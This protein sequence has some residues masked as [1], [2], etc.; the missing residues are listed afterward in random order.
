MQQARTLVDLA[1]VAASHDDRVPAFGLARGLL[2]PGGGFGAPWRGLGPVSRGWLAEAGV[3]TPAE[4]QACDAIALWLQVRRLHPQAG[5]NLLYALVG[6]QRGQDWRTVAR[7]DRSAL[8]LE[9]DL[10]GQAPG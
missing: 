2:S 9:L 5:L 1:D 3:H 8:M 7:E 10:R 6:A 4:L